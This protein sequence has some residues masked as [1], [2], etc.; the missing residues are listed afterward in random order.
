MI[1]FSPGY[2]A[3]T[4]VSLQSVR[5]FNLL[6]YNVVPTLTIQI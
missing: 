5:R 3:T 2:S 6:S 4:A 1:V